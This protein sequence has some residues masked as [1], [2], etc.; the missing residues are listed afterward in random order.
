MDAGFAFEDRMNCNLDKFFNVFPSVNFTSKIV[1]ICFFSGKLIGGCFNERK[2]TVLKKL[3]VVRQK[4][5]KSRLFNNSIK[6]DTI[7]LKRITE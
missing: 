7:S 5:T 1:R 3:Y 2:I 6:T 4:N